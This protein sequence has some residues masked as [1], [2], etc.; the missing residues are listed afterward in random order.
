MIARTHAHGS[1]FYVCAALAP[2][3]R[4]NKHSVPQLQNPHA[5]RAFRRGASHSPGTRNARSPSQ[6]HLSQPEPGTSPAVF[7]SRPHRAAYRRRRRRM[8]LLKLLPPETATGPTHTRAV[9]QQVVY[10]AWWLRRS[11]TSSSSAPPSPSVSSSPRRRY[12]PPRSLR[13]CVPI[14]MQRVPAPPSPETLPVARPGVASGGFCMGRVGS[15]P[16]GPR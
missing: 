6:E 8:R 10:V 9:G 16:R 5:T 12:H 4:V 15:R 14:K 11:S 13:R 2:L 3:R 1:F 7:S